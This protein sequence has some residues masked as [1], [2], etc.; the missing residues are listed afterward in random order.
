MDNVTIFRSF[1]IKVFYL[2]SFKG[3]EDLLGQFEENNI[4]PYTS[5]GTSSKSDTLIK[6]VNEPKGIKSLLLNVHGIVKFLLFY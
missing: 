4:P 2:F 6:D 3:F 1:V 5:N